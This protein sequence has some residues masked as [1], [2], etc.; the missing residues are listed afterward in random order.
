MAH[1]PVDPSF[2]LWAIFEGMWIWAMDQGGT[3]GIARIGFGD[4]HLMLVF[5]PVKA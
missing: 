2:E 3:H 4:V 5:V 1:L